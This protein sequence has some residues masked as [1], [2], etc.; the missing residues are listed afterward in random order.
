ME[1]EEKRDEIEIEIERSRG[2]LVL[3][4]EADPSGNVWST[5]K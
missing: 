2:R 3:G 5:W 1:K 4:L